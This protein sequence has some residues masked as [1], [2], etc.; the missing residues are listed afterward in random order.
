MAIIPGKGISSNSVPPGFVT[1]CCS[2]ITS[3]YNAADNCKQ[4][5]SLCIDSGAVIEG[6]FLELRISTNANWC[7]MEYYNCKN[8]Y[9]NSYCGDMV[10]RIEQPDPCVWEGEA[11]ANQVYS[12][13]MEDRRLAGILHMVVDPDTC[14]LLLTARN[15]YWCFEIQIEN[16]QGF[17]PTLTEV[18]PPS[19]SAQIPYGYAVTCI[20]PTQCERDRMVALP[21][22][23]DPGFCGIAV[24]CHELY[25]DCV[26]STANSSI[27]RICERYYYDPGEKVHVLK[28]GKV[29]V[30]LFSIPSSLSDKLAYFT[31]GNRGLIAPFSYSGT[32]PAN[33]IEIENST[34]LE[35]DKKN[36]LALIELY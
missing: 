14:C 35:F 21:S 7:G 5:A 31:A 8:E 9:L 30:P 15:P 18:N 24:R 28:K 1:E 33:T 10:F 22:D 23:A 36:S 6:D 34:L 19:L 13:L 32:P 11:M 17:I 4:V 25:E 16:S 26:G 27:N 12:M 29:W 2:L 3:G 20:S